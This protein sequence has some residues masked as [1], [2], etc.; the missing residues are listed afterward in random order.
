MKITFLGTGTSQGVPIIGCTCE[1]CSST[2]KKD[3]RLRTSVLVQAQ[4]KNIVIDSGPDFREQMLRTKINRLD[5]LLITHAHKDHIAGL[6]DIRAFNF[7]QKEAIDVYCTEQVEA[8]LR[9]EFAYIFAEK[10]YPGI[11]ELNIH[12]IYPDK[13]FEVA[14]IA[15]TPVEVLHLK[16]PVL[17]FKIADFVYITDANYIAA[18]QMAKIKGCKI[19]VLNA[20]RHEKHIS[21]FTLSEALEIVKEVNPTQAYFTHISHQLG[22]HEVVSQTLPANTQLA[23]DGLTLQ[24]EW[25]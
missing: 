6:D 22:L 7:I 19:F 25:P 23:F 3:N 13:N 17:G 1:V 5:G 18:N 4:G 9:R 16:L 12:N 11:P 10:R 21:H 14:G 24:T 15:I 20:L 2:N 8:Q